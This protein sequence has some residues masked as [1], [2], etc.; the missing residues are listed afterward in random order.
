MVGEAHLGRLRNAW[1]TLAVGPFAPPNLYLTAVD[2]EVVLPPAIEAARQS[3]TE[4][5]ASRSVGH[6]RPVDNDCLALRAFDVSE[7][8]RNHELPR[9]RLEFCRTSYFRGRVTNWQLDR[10]TMLDGRQT[11]LRTA[12]VAQHDLR[13]S[14]AP[15]LAN[16]WGIILTIV[17]SDAWVL[18]PLRGQTEVEANCF[19]PSVGEEGLW[20]RDV[21]DGGTIDPF[22]I[23]AAGVEEELGITLEPRHLQWLEFGANTV[24]CRYALVGLVNIDLTRSE[25]QSAMST[26]AKDAWEIR[27]PA[28]ARFAPESVAAF[29]SEPGRRFSPYAT[30]ALTRAL[31]QKFGWSRCASAFANAEIDVVRSTLRL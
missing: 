4:A 6:H 23:A 7:R 14:P 19:G 13:V 25:L 15:S 3:F 20:S 12:V 1:L 27:A 30:A 5:V 9:L 11:T 2:E 21:L 28:W 17:T 18:V 10:P 22:R 24:C 16:I 8:T 26:N 31:L 29:M